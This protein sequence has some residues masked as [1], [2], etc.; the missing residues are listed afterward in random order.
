MARITVITT[1]MAAITA[2]L[3]IITIIAIMA[4]I[5]IT[6]TTTIIGTQ[7][8]GMVEIPGKII[9]I[10]ANV[11]AQMRVTAEIRDAANQRLL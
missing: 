9:T 4:I 1:V 5:V 8:R 11:I 6:T 3:E 7:I 2:I 10:E